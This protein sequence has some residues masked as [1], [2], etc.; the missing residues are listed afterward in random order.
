MDS[1]V[2]FVVGLNTPLD[3]A[4][5]RKLLRDISYHAEGVHGGNLIEYIKS[6]LEDYQFTLRE[7]YLVAYQVVLNQSD[8]IVDGTRP[9]EELAKEIVQ[10]LKS[11]IGWDNQSSVKQ[12]NLK[13]A[14]ISLD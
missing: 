13:I 8:L 7:I 11:H 10:K 6:E 2:D 12:Q 14:K 1:L 5:A 9:A 3:I 4:L